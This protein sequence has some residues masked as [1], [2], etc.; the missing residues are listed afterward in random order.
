MGAPAMGAPA[1]DARGIEIRRE[2]VGSGTANDL[3]R[4]LDTEL[5]ALYPE[6]GTAGHFRLDAGEVSPGRGAFLVAY[7]GGR[8]LACGAIRRLDADMAEI[9]RMYVAPAARG[10]GLGR[11]ILA[12][13]EAEASA[14]G[15]KRIVLETGPRQPE[16][17][18]LY[19]SAGYSEIG[20]FGEYAPSLLSVFM[21]KEL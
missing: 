3:I 5:S 21:G 20:A 6:E 2:A 8:P 14:L 16:A 13:L 19:T 12:A 10:C 17:I 11:R 4:A 1:M 15:V 9:K 7:V 18:A